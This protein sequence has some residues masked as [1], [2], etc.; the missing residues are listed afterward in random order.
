MENLMLAEHALGIRHCILC[1]AEW[2]FP[3]A[4]P[5]KKNYVYQLLI[6]KNN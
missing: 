4:A 2:K 3:N 6:W 1:Y 5:R